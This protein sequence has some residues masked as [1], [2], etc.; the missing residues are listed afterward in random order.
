MKKHSFFAAFLLIATHC[1]YAQVF[2]GAQY[3]S[4]SSDNWKY[5]REDVVMLENAIFTTAFSASLGY[6]IP[7]IRTRI[8]CI[9]PVFGYT[10]FR[11]RMLHPNSGQ[12]AELA[13]TSP[14]L[15]V[16]V[17]HYPFDNQSQSFGATKL[18]TAPAFRKGFFVAGGV[19][20][21]MLNTS[22]EYQELNV[23]TNQYNTVKGAY[24]QTAWSFGFRTGFDFGIS[25]R[26]TLSPM[27]G[28]SWLTGLN[29]TDFFS[30][31]RGVASNSIFLTV[32]EK[33]TRSALMFS[34]GLNVKVH[35]GK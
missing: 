29:G 25:R 6:E 20:F 18:K 12:S 7:L 34:A 21:R 35:F 33:D 1:L 28:I 24:D 31:D 27:A 14:S 13:L 2:V 23:V 10:S 19:G 3:S 22:L 16:F 30:P 5:E 32:D 17:I 15:E 11:H 26:L 9:A 8:T 4:L